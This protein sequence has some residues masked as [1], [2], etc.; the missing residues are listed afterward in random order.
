MTNLEG[1]VKLHFGNILDQLS[2]TQELLDVRRKLG[3]EHMIELEALNNALE[4]E[5]ETRMSLELKLEGL[6]EFV[7]NI[8]IGLIKPFK[9]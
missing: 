5:Q 4:E 7:N 9:F 2:H 6:D 3:H 8:V 1:D